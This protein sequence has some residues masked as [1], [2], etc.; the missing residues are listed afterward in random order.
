MNLLK[1]LNS[2]LLSLL[3]LCGNSVYALEIDYDEWDNADVEFK[4]D[5]K[6]LVAEKKAAKAL[7]ERQNNIKKTEASRQAARS[8]ET[9]LKANTAE[10]EAKKNR[11]QND[12]NAFLD[13][14]LGSAP[15]NILVRAEKI[16]SNGRTAIHDASISGDAIALNKLLSSKDISFINIKDNQ[17]N[18]PLHHAVLNNR[19]EAIDALLNKN[20]RVN[21]KNSEGKTPLDIAFSL[22]EKSKLDRLMNQDV[23][24]RLRQYGAKTSAELATRR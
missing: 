10:K 1:K 12:T 5:Q 20:A 19:S 15:K 22:S 6:K 17:N 2:T 16:D 3:L 4:D 13:N 23:I 8:A 11:L 14:I 18:T 21:E 9:D 24:K 7:A